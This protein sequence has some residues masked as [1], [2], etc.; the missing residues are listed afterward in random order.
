[1]KAVR[2]WLKAHL[3]NSKV[4]LTA[5][6]VK[7][8][9]K[10]HINSS[11]ESIMVSLQPTGQVCGNA[12]LSYF[13]E[14]YLIRL[15]G[16]SPISDPYRWHPSYWSCL[17]MGRALLEFGYAVDVI[18]WRN[19]WFVP[20]KKYDIFIDV[21]YNM[22]RLAPIMPDACV[23]IFF[24]DT[25]HVLFHN[26]A[27]A[28]RLLNLQQR[29]GV[30]LRH[31]RNEWPNRGVDYA[32]SVIML[33]NSF[34]YSTYKYA[35]KPIFAVPT[36]SSQPFSIAEN[37][38]FKACRHHYLWLGNWGFI[39]KGLD[40]VL[41]AFADLP[42][43]HLTVCGPISEEEEFESE[44]HREL[45]DCPNIHTLG[46]VD[47]ASQQFNEI[48]NS[49]IGM[50]FA[51]CSEG[52]CGGVINCM[53]GGLIPIV[54]WESGVDVADFGIIL[55]SST[56]AEIKEAVQHVSRMPVEDLKTMAYKASEYARNAHS[57]E[58]F[59]REYRN[60]LASILGH[61]PLR[62]LPT[63]IPMP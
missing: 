6:E 59:S 5:C 10:K 57:R 24:A 36:V 48:L 26:H 47:T 21:R 41:E 44:Y 55:K 62:T 23:K 61:E 49:C 35:G 56:V 51:S 63:D 32:D 12:L 18:H 42:N 39:H 31:S 11:E 15:K 9:I 27:E 14:P 30:S 16:K 19:S 38:D 34:T 20:R 50:V 17:E 33:G 13:N 43:Y 60:A 29:R 1:M 28:Q 53:A 22:E 8:T 52:Q 58:S 7:G 25:A 4:W 46:W 40:V 3:A 37:K 2:S 45:Y 54:S